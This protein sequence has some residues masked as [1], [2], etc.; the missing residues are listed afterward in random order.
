MIK[1][2]SGE[3][4]ISENAERAN[5]ILSVIMAFA[6]LDFSH[7]IELSE[8]GEDILDAISG[9]VN[10][11]GEE[12]QVSTIS[13]KEKEQ[14]LKEIHHRVKN[15]LQIV[16]S[17]LSLQSQDSKDE[18]FLALIRESRNRISSMALVH[19]MLYA[20]KNLS[21]IS[22]QEYVMRLSQSI[23]NSFKS[24][25]Q[26]VDFE[27]RMDPK[28]SF[29]IDRMIPIGLIINEVI[30]NALK[31]AFPSKNGIISISLEEDGENYN[32]Q[33]GDNGIGLPHGFDVSK[34]T[35]LGMQL[36]FMLSEQLGG[37]AQL[38][39]HEGTY[40]SIRFPKSEK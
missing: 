33:A 24:P 10:M 23:Q 21:D 30:S 36:I 17:L 27:Y 29:D 13:L 12:L 4:N 37:T 1:Q 8:H 9:G 31:Y 7:K 26:Q 40:F 20:S 25:D 32:L 18:A 5:K 22:I 11:L 38:L 16:S 35:N 19:E 34:D 14:L 2:P 6:R 15:N 3:I 39:Q 28:L